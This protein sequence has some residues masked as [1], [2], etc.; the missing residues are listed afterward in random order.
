M[1][2]AKFLFWSKSQAADAVDVDDLVAELERQSPENAK[3]LARGR[4][5]VT[6]IFYGNRPD[7]AGKKRRKNRAAVPK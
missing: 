3:A 6:D 4:K 5:W 7:L 1:I 2:F